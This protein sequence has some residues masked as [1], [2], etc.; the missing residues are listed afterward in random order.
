MNKIAGGFLKPEDLV[1]KLQ[2]ALGTGIRSV[3]L[4]GSAAAGDHV[5]KRSDYNVLVVAEKL[6]VGE[7]MKLSTTALAWRKAG[8]PPPLLFTLDRLQRSADVFPIELLDIKESHRILHGQDVLDQVEVHPENVRLV[9]ERELKS[10]LIRLR[11]G[12]LFTQGKS[13]KVLDLMIDSLSTFLVLFRAGLRLYQDDVPPLK[14][15]AMHA[16]SERVRFDP[17][18][19]VTVEQLKEGKRGVKDVNAVALFET[20]LRTVE[21]VV[22]AVD[23]HIHSTG[24]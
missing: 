11:D 21:S 8:N 16:F 10:N 9:L 1:G 12:F 5:G 7:L 6:G 2:Q 13:E 18:V 23:Q 19:F 14:M 24:S 22:D 15:D 20:Y 3:I 4:Y 17:G